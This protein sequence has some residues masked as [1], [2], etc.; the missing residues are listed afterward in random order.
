MPNKTVMNE[1]NSLLTTLN[2]EGIIDTNDISDGFH[3]FGDLYQQRVYLSAAL[4]N[5]WSDIS[6]KS[7]KHA[8]GEIP[9]CGNFFVCGIFTPEGQYNYHYEL[10]YWD[11]FDIPELERAPEW[12]GHTSED[13]QRVM[14]VLKEKPSVA[15]ICDGEAC[16]KCH[17]NAEECRHCTDV[18]HAKNFEQLSM[19]RWVERD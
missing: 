16:E 6:W 11:L 4:F 1:I 13:V 2:D 19:N 18:R 15:Y 5:T 7:K 14:S 8:D 9:F 17:S 10:K 12:D 3:T